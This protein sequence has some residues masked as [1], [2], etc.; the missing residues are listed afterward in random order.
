L[1]TNFAPVQKLCGQDSARK[2]QLGVSKVSFAIDKSQW[3]KAS[4]NSSGGHYDDRAT[5]Y[6]NIS[7]RCKK[8][9]VSCV[10]S[11]EDQKRAYEIEK[12]F[13]WWLPSL[14]PP[15]LTEVE[16]LLDEARQSQELW[17]KRKAELKSDREFLERWIY[18]LVQI[19]AYGKKAN[20]DMITMLRRCLEEAG[21]GPVA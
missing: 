4:L 9:E 16:A 19:S 18:V 2:I 12:R 15:C 3:S 20:T 17:D 11:A 6:E 13:V 7:Y 5:H 14:C 8:C 10:F 21:H 1:H